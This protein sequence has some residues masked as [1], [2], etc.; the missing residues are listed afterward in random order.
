MR[1]LA[2][3][4]EFRNLKIGQEL[5]TACEELIAA[6]GFQHITLHTT[7]LMQ[8]AKA[9]YERRGYTR[10]PQIDFTPSPDFVVYGFIKEIGAK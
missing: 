8:T 6:K 4:P 7:Q 3:L 1:L 9:M 10:F 5:I 2:V